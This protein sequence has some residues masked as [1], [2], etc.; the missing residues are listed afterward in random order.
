MTNLNDI[1]KY[2]EETPE[3]TN[4][5]ILLQMV[6]DYNTSSIKGLLKEV[7]VV[8]EVVGKGYY[9]ID[10]NGVLRKGTATIG[11]GDSS[12]DLPIEVGTRYY[13]DFDL[14]SITSSEVASSLF[15]E[16]TGYQFL[17]ITDKEQI[18]QATNNEIPTL[19]Y[20]AQGVNLE[21]YNAFQNK[22]RDTLINFFIFIYQT[23]DKQKAKDYI[24]KHS[25]SDEMSYY[26][27]SNK[28]AYT[29]TISRKSSGGTDTPEAPDDFALEYGIKHFT[30]LAVNPTQTD[31]ENYFKNN[32]NYHFSSQSGE[33]L[34]NSG[35]TQTIPSLSY[36][37]NGYKLEDYNSTKETYISFQYILYDSIDKQNI[38][39]FLK[40][41]LT[42]EMLKQINY[43]TIQD[44]Y[45]YIEYIVGSQES[46]S[47]YTEGKSLVSYDRKDGLYIRNN[48]TNEVTQ[49]YSKGR[50]WNIH[51]RWLQTNSKVIATSVN[52]GVIVINSTDDS[53]TVL[54]DSDT[55]D[56]FNNND[57]DNMLYIKNA[58]N[59]K[60]ISYNLETGESSITDV[61]QQPTIKIL[62]FNVGDTEYTF[63]E[64]TIF[65]DWLGSKYNTDGFNQ[66][67]SNQ[68]QNAE[69]NG[70]LMLDNKAVSISETISTTTYSW[71]IN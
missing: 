12:E 42:G 39:N 37:C 46:R 17:G 57:A 59:T 69:K 33:A 19:N 67:E 40:S 70:I 62:K 45:S 49:I 55:W 54:T 27:I 56:D 47:S 64:G 22:E 26:Y 28:M 4:P 9:F 1:K 10:A 43:Y 21:E 38:I 58:T 66:N 41:N 44:S 15:N 32:E 30:D 63:E 18:L 35:L 50:S 61:E 20:M 60:Q 6:Q 13:K 14:A 51:D 71:M 68:I 48:T 3:N 25:S 29:E 52:N 36:M 2:I 16:K 5:V 7:N 34:V 24:T 65:K 11:S 53:I 31:L 8:P 23:E